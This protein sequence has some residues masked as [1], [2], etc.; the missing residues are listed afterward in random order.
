VIFRTYFRHRAAQEDGFALIEVIISALLVAVIVVATLTGFDA[1]GRTTSDQRHHD[2]AAVLASE[3][4][5]Q[6]RSDPATTLATIEGSKS[7]TYTKTFGGETYT[8]TQE[9]AYVN[10]ATQHAGCSATGSESTS[11]NSDNYIRV[12]STV[13]WPQL[14]S[15]AAIT[16]ASNI[17]PPDGSTLEVDVKNG[18]EPLAAVSGVTVL[19]AGITTTTGETGCVV[20]GS[21]PATTVNLEAY[22]PN[23]VTENGAY[24]VSAEEL[25]IAPNITTH[26]PITFA[27]GGRITASFMY[28][29]EAQT[30]DTFVVY[31]T[32]MKTSPTFEVGSTSGKFAGSGLY[33]P[34]T[35]TFL[36]SATTPVSAT[37]YVNGNLFPFPKAPWTVYAGDC[38]EN[39]PSNV[40]G[41]VVKSG[42]ATVTA[43]KNVVVSVPMSLLEINVYKGTS[44]STA[45]STALPVTI[46]NYKCVTTLTPNNE[47]KT[48]NTHK[49]FTTSSGHLER[50]YQP[51]GKFKL[52][53]YVS[54]T[55][56]SQELEYENKGTVG[57]KFKLY[58]GQ[59][60]SYETE[61]EKV[62][63]A[64]T[65]KS[66]NLC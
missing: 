52:C 4:Q 30:G 1:I 9:A 45:E 43:G 44:G 42:T 50:P 3:S 21:L 25:T 24:N 13:T 26:Y 15:R 65:V 8:V 16:Q 22:K 63:Y 35:G 57:A 64:V 7:H 55:N 51:F 19:A 14:G 28:S 47:T 36:S 53:T 12:K 49:Q 61:V 33:E 5:E 62:K 27:E 11:K 48:T 20:Y 17:T 38:P 39:N 41:G 34:G 2:Q 31:N 40:T 58:A 59:K 46:T 18:G 60:S 23:Y 56:D 32:E 29:G 10:D 6:L 66:G 37:N 54:A